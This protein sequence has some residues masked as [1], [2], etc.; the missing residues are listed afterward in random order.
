MRPGRL[1]WR[2]LDYWFRPGVPAPVESPARAYNRAGRVHD[3]ACGPL[4]PG[5]PSPALHQAVNGPRR[6]TGLPV[7]R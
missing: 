7:A 1:R 4:P 5:T 6:R 3:T 2:A